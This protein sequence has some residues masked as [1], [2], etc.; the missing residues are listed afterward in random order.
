MK[1]QAGNISCTMDNGVATITI[2]H[3][4]KLNAL[5]DAMRGELLD[6]VCH[7]DVNPDVRVIVI[8]GAGNAFCTGGDIEYLRDLKNKNDEAE[9]IRLLDEGRTLVQTL[10]NSEKP[11][12]ALI[13]GPAFGGGLIIAMACDL[14]FCSRTASFGMSFIKIGL[15]PDWGGTYLLT[16]LVGTARALEMLWT[17][18]RLS[19]DEAM[20]FGLA[21]QV[22]PGAE[23]AKRGQEVAAQLARRPHEILARYKKAVYHAANHSFDEAADL[24]RRYQLENFRSHHLTEGISAFLEKRLSE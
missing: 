14:R 15:G 5:T 24:E 19:A 13:D 1:N 18:E 6:C 3:P 8:T 17:G 22:W 9:F 16:R 23:L 20:R 7:A 10:R 12:I 21:D 2:S 11:A 4:G